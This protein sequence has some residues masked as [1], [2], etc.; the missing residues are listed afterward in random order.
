MIASGALKD[1]STICNFGGDDVS[2]DWESKKRIFRYAVLGP[3]E[4]NVSGDGSPGGCEE[5][6]VWVVK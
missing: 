4:E 6:S 3:A 2:G 5:F 1:V